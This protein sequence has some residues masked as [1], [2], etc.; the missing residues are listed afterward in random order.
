[1]AIGTYQT[2]C[3]TCFRVFECSTLGELLDAVAT[4]EA[5]RNCS[6]PVYDAREGRFVDTEKR[7][8]QTGGVMPPCVSWLLER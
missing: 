1:M 5:Q 4:H 8:R 3:C 7:Q 2:H 6:R